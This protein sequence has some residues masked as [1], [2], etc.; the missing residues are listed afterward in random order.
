MT[1]TIE[2][3][4]CDGDGFDATYSK[5][6]ELC[7]GRGKLDAE[8][9]PRHPLTRLERLEAMADAGTD[10]WEEYREER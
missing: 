5:S 6:C 3:H 1:T 10:T 4:R 2:C 8:P 9:E 7:G